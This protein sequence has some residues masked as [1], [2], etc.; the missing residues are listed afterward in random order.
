MVFVAPGERFFYLNVYLQP[1][2]PGV[3]AEFV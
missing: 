2:E 1:D 3:V